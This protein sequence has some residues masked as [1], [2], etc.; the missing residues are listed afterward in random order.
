MQK[1]S[2]THSCWS[3]S[4]L[5]VA[6]CNELLLAG[7]G[8]WRIILIICATAARQASCALWRR[9]T[10]GRRGRAQTSAQTGPTSARRAWGKLQVVSP[11]KSRQWRCVP[12]LPRVPTKNS[13]VHGPRPRDRCT[14]HIA[15]CRHVCTCT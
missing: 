13:G 1:A 5:E 14:L 12:R 15:Q 8:I 6:E 4:D 2:E 7:R 10:R 9:G 3:N 11:C